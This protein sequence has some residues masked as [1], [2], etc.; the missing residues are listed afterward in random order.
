MLAGP[1]YSAV[2][3]LSRSGF[4]TQQFV[5]TWPDL[6]P[7]I[8]LTSNATAWTY[9]NWSQIIAK[10]AITSDYLVTRVSISGFDVSNALDYQIE[11]GYGDSSSEVQIRDIPFHH[12]AVADAQCTT[13][14][15]SVP[16]LI[17]TNVRLAARLAT[18]AIASAKTLKIAVGTIG[19][20]L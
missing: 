3:R 12:E 8:T 14:N 1:I 19:L 2:L 9:G 20:P 5:H 18:S 13:I 16:T 10:D 11:L 15:F 6:A 4:A 17:L 7:P